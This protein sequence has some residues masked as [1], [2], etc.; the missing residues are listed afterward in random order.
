[1]QSMVAVNVFVAFYLFVFYFSFYLTI[2]LLFFH[3]TV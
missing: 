1:M 2:L 3:P